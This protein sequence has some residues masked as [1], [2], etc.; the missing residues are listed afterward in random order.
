MENKDL[1]SSREA[2]V[3][4]ALHFI[5]QYCVGTPEYEKQKQELISALT[6]NKKGGK[7]INHTVRR[8]KYVR[9]WSTSKRKEKKL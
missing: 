9:G 7:K 2:L 1:S 8:K 5:N 4:S 3:T 6:N